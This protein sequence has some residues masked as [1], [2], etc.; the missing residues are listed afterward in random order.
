MIIFSKKLNS[1]LWPKDGTLRGTTTRGQS[2]PG[3]NGNEEVLH[4][5]QTPELESLHQMQFSVIPKT[6]DRGAS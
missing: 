6:L 3:S 2:E 1:S 4:I 5:P